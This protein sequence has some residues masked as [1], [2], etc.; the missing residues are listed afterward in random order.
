MPAG[1]APR[2]LME[3]QKVNTSVAWGPLF[4]DIT[5]YRISLKSGSI[6]GRETPKEEIIGGCG[7]N[8]LCSIDS[9]KSPLEVR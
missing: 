4:A 3:G 1:T 9:L 6:G 2:E 8:P 5:P 7:T